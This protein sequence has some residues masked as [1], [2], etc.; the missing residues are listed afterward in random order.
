MTT[1]GCAASRAVAGRST[2]AIVRV[3]SLRIR[4]AASPH[5]RVRAADSVRRRRAARQVGTTARQVA[6]AAHLVGTKAR[7]VG[8]KARPAA[9]AALMGMTDRRVPTAAPPAGTA[10]L[11]V[12]AARRPGPARRRQCRR[13][14]TPPRRARI[15]PRRSRSRSSAPHC[16][17]RWMR[18]RTPSHRP[19]RRT[20]HFR[21]RRAAP[22]RHRRP[23]GRGPTVSNPAWNRRRCRSGRHARSA[24]VIKG[25]MVAGPRRAAA[26]PRR[27]AHR[28][29]RGSAGPPAVALRSLPN[30]PVR[31]S[32]SAFRSPGSI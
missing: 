17:V 6:T 2:A 12:I 10:A 21:P 31:R 5:Q 3:R 26:P 9:T 15:R 11:V 4:P 24:E 8:T 16:G 18:S 27:R 29:D 30:P 32:R 25:R 13:N 7:Q 19:A 23:D 20:G 14:R 22:D 28:A 1:A